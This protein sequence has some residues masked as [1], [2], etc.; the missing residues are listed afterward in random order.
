MVW[1]F[2]ELD[3]WIRQSAFMEANF[4]DAVPM[5]PRLEDEFREC[6]VGLMGTVRCAQ[7]HLGGQALLIGD[8]AHC[9]VPFHGQGVNAAFE[10][11]T[12]LLDLFDAG[13]V[14]WEAL[15][16][17]FQESRK[18]NTDALADMSM[19]AYRTMRESARHRDFMLRKALERELGRRH[20]DRFVARYS[21]VM[22]HRIPYL[23]A[24]GR[25]KVQS[26]ILDELLQ[27]K[28]ALAEM[29]FRQADRLI[30]DRLSLIANL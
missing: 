9:I 3:S 13:A 30:T 12:S 27:G 25:G 22:F 16:R 20:P 23:E 28:S 24:F 14:E 1:G 21:L 8:A 5:I 11:C 29:D 2:E 10:D 4:P 18:Q 17:R 26:A 7:W 15:F 6:R 19:D